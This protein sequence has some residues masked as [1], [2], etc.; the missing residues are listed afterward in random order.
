M[1]AANT[2]HAPARI[3]K[4]YKASTRTWEGGFDAP[5]ASQSP[6]RQPPSGA[7]AG[8]RRRSAGPHT[9][10]C[11]RPRR[12]TAT[13]RCCLACSTHTQ[14]QSAVLNARR[15]HESSTEANTHEQPPQV[16]GA[17]S[18]E[19]C[20]T[21]GESERRRRIDGPRAGGRLHP[22]AVP[23]ACAGPGRADAR[24][25]ARGHVGD[26]GVKRAPAPRRRLEGPQ[27]TEQRAAGATPTLCRV[28]AGERG[29]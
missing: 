6:S 24:V 25:R 5:S 8:S 21:W 12:R 16:S 14:S 22:R 9:R 29:R 7:A 11:P 1:S 17:R 26:V 27:L 23:R 18:T 20:E 13:R 19:N 2:A 4:Q 28:Q 15:V 3:G 10:R